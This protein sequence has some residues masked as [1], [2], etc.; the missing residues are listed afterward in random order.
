MKKEP[1]LLG[2]EVPFVDVYIVRG[3]LLRDLQTRVRKAEYEASLRTRIIGRLLAKMRVG[4][5]V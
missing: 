1:K 5:K 2:V 3:R 4:G